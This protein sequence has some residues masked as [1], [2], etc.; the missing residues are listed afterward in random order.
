[1]AEAFVETIKQDYAR[2]NPRPDATSVLLQ[3]LRQQMFDLRAR[4][5]IN[6]RFTRTTES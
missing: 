2:V 6:E 3:V 4:A 1:M 5:V